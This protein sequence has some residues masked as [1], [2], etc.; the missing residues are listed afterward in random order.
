MAAGVLATPATV[1]AQDD[2]DREVVDARLEG[3]SQ[4]GTTAI[5]DV[6]KPIPD[7]SSLMWFVLGAFALI[8][9]GGLFK[10][11]RRTHLD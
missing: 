6:T 4:E 9:A 2:E 11:A 10:D 5:V 3:L 1:L 8:A 7:R